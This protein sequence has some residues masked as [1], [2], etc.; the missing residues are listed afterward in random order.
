MTVFLPQCVGVAQFPQG[1]VTPNYHML[2][3]GVVAERTLAT[4]LRVAAG[5]DTFQIMDRPLEAPRPNPTSCGILD[6]S[7]LTRDLLLI[8]SL[9]TIHSPLLCKEGLGEVDPGNP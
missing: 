1:S 9:V 8:S 3:A 6:P 5:R 4:D 2:L 7:E